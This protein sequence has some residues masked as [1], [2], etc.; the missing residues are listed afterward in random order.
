MCFNTGKGAERIAKQS[1]ADE[2]A[3]QNRITQGM[4]QINT[5]F[6]NAFDEAFYKGRQQAYVDYATPSLERQAQEA[7]K[8]LIFALSRTGNLD[9]SAANERNADLTRETNDARVGI[10]NQGLDMANDSRRQVEGARSG[11]V[12]ELNATGDSTAAAATALRQA[13]NLATPQGYSPLGQLFEVF[14]RT[15]SA[16]GSNANNNYRGLIG[17]GRSLFGAGNGSA[18]V[19]G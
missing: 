5:T 1:R 3:R 12:A 6:D 15:A 16:I 13:T 17:G 8:N 7:R 11:V 2:V 9:S 4:G 18:R 10:A 14:S 19:V